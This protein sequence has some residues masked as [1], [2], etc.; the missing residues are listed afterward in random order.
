M[1]IDH[2]RTRKNSTGLTDT[3]AG[4]GPDPGES[5]PLETE[6]CRMDN[7]MLPMIQSL[8]EK[9]RDAVMMAEVDGLTQKEIAGKL[10]ISISGA[11]SRVQRGRA[12]MKGM[13]LDCCRFY[14]DRRGN[15]IDYDRRSPSSDTP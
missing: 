5:E 4:N 3:L 15:I 2:Y 10:G 14:F 8:P 13:L 9:Y 11:K 6:T 12:I 7:C 1:H